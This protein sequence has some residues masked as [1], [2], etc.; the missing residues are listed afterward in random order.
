V[1][2]VVQ[3]AVAG[4]LVEVRAQRHV[5]RKRLAA[6]PQL[7]HH[8]LRHVLGR[9]ALAQQP[10]GR[11]DQPRVVRAEDGRE[12]RVASL[13]ELAQQ[14]RVVHRG[15]IFGRARALIGGPG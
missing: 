5:G 8:L 1:A 2:D 13:A 6:A 7:Q 11:G 10:L 9:R 15:C 4:A 14:F 3:R 12:R